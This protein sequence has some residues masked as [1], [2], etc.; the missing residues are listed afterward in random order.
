MEKFNT[1]LIDLKKAS[2]IAILIVIALFLVTCSRSPK[3]IDPTKIR[4]HNL[5]I[6][7]IQL[8]EAI[9]PYLNPTWANQSRI[10][11]FYWEEGIWIG[12]ENSDGTVTTEKRCDGSIAYGTVVWSPDD[13]FILYTGAEK[14]LTEPARIFQCEVETGKVSPVTHERGTIIL[15]WE[16]EIFVYEARSSH[17]VV[18]KREKEVYRIPLDHFQNALTHSIQIIDQEYLLI[19]T[20]NG[21]LLK[22]P[23]SDYKNEELIY[24][25][26]A[27]AQND[28]EKKALILG[29]PS[30]SPNQR[31][32]LWISDDYKN[33]LNKSVKILD[34]QTNQVITI[35][36]YELTPQFFDKNNV[37]GLSLPSWS[38]DS[39]SLILLTSDRT[40]PVETIWMIDLFPDLE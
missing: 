15:D 7:A 8:G 38:P 34:R 1:H 13:K 5:E 23:F 10:F 18:I 22:V 4:F 30:I 27:M 19:L 12:H 20:G 21:R 33:W 26:E 28:E 35:M 37:M 11:S 9:S 32:I 31:W 36:S 25:D 3:E 2:R 39:T 14:S 40:T 29:S 17:E 24:Q 16:E 6:E